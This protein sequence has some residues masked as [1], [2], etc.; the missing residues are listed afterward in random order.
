MKKTL[1]PLGNGKYLE[2]GQ[3]KIQN[4]LPYIRKKIEYYLPIEMVDV[5]E[6]KKVVSYIRVNVN[7]DCTAQEVNQLIAQIKGL[8]FEALDHMTKYERYL[9]EGRK[10]DD[11][12]GS[13]EDI[14]PKT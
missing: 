5:D 13:G 8:L 7:R 4:A 6:V 14:L 10:R 1:Y 12:E 9:S 2:V 11:Q 3:N